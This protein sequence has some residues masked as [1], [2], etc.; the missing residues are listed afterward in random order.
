VIDRL[1]LVAPDAAEEIR[2]RGLVS[3]RLGLR[4]AAARD[5]ETYLAR[6]PDAP[7]EA[8]IRERLGALR[9]APGFLN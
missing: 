2:D 7:D 8:A 9:A 3:E 4:P 6:A 1:V 5:L